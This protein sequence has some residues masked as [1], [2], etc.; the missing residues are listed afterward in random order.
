MLSVS[1]EGKIADQQSGAVKHFSGL[2][3]YVSSILNSLLYLLRI[4]FFWLYGEKKGEQNI[5][6]LF[7]EWILQHDI[8]D[9]F[10]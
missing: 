2:V 6:I 8:I 7:V 3:F 4:L 9:S 1:M 10:I 5:T